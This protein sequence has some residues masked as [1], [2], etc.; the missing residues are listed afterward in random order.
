MVTGIK[1]RFRF[2]SIMSVEGP[3]KD[4]ACVCVCMYILYGF[5]K[6]VSMLKALNAIL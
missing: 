6:H 5:P 1:V 2:K 4:S 3:H